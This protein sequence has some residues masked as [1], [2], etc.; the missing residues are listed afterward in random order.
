MKF[1][2]QF[3]KYM[4]P[5]EGEGGEGSASTGEEQKQQDQQVDVK[6]LQDELERLRA[7]HEK[8]L[9]ETKAA[10]AERQREEAARQAAQEEAARKAGDV[11]ALEK[12]WQ[13]KYS[14]LESEAKERTEKLQAQINAMLIDGVASTMA[15][16][17]AVEPEVADLL[18]EQI[19][20]S[21]GV[22]ERDGKLTTAVLED[23]K[24]SAMT[25]DE[26]K[27]SVQT[28]PK[29]ARLVKGSPAS[30][31]GAGDTKPSGGAGGDNQAAEAAKKNKD[32]NGFLGAALNFK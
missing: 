23:G 9:T 21:L 12:S 18:A 7:H 13:G 22:T 32:L 28:N 3:L 20:K 1:R 30:G 8:L 11:E 17:L 15:L 25:L 19:K 2:N 24:P 5:Q 16:E 4:A 14:K 27:K 6:A 31:A 26:L 10:K 29:F